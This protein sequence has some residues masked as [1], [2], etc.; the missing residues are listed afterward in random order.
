MF[1]FFGANTNT[2]RIND[3]DTSF[4]YNIKSLRNLIEKLKKDLDA[5]R[6]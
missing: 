6:V 4:S 2:L 1:G 5:E 3:A